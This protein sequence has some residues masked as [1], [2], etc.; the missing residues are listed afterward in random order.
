MMVIVYSI[1]NNYDSELASSIVSLTAII[2]FI[3][4]FLVAA[5]FNFGF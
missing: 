2:S 4:V 3:L 1:E 5:M